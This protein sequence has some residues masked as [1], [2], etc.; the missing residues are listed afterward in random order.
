MSETR[1]RAVMFDLDGTLLDTA[2]DFVAVL[3]RLLDE[4][5]RPAPPPERIRRSVSNGARALVQLG[6]GVAEADAD[7]E[8][9]RARLLAIYADHIAVHTRPF[10]GIQALL[11]Q[12]QAAG[13]PWGIAT[14]KPA[15]Y[16]GLLLDA[17][18]LDPA[19]ASVICPDHVKARKPD[20][21]SLYL[22]AQQLG[23]EPGEI[24]YVGDHERDIACGRRAGA[25]TIAVGYGYIEDDDDINRWQADH[26]V[27]HAEQI[28]P[29]LATRIHPPLKEPC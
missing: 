4:E 6:F 28:W 3:N 15:L 23:C 9:L 10:P 29:L 25:L 17:L 20:P 16:T 19:P 1:I 24:A 21:E 14:N 11:E 18:Q 22:A 5:G 27:E 2:P 8:R 7:Y 26:Q 13:I 12:L